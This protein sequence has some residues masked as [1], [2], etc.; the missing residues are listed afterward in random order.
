[1]AKQTFSIEID[2]DY[3]APEGPIETDA[4][5]VAFV[6][7]MAAKSYANH[8]DAATPL[9]GITVARERRNAD[10]PPP[11]EAPEEGGDA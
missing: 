10:P 9:E 6:M 2:D 1:M 5:Y 8:P 7:N 4:D 11:V 3:E